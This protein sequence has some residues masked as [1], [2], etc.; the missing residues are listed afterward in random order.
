VTRLNSTSVTPVESVEDLW[1]VHLQPMGCDKCG[2]A[3]LAP[4]SFVGRPCPDCGRDRLIPQPALLRRE[5]PELAF[6][7]VKRRADLAHILR[8]FTRGVWIHTEDF[9]PDMLLQRAVPVYWPMWLVDSDIFGD[10]RAEMGYDYQV[11]SSQE[12]YQSGSW[13]TRPVVETRIRWEPRVGQITRRY[14]NIAAP[15]VSDHD[16]LIKLVGRYPLDKGIDYQPSMLNTDQG[17]VMMK[18]PDLPVESAWPLA[19][20]NLKKAAGFDCQ[21][22]AGAQHIR[23]FA[24]HAGYKS[25][26]WTQLLL[27]VYVTYYHD[28]EGNPKLV[29]VNGYSGSAGGLRLASQRKGWQWAGIMAAIAV[30]LFVLGMIFFGL[31]MVFPPSAVV[32]ILL[33]ILAFLGGAA[34]I[35]P[36]AWPWQWNRAQ[37]SQKVVRR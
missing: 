26:E 27:P 11:K 5:A 17:P 1:G 35:I 6:P 21:K 13:H 20:T 2:H 28:D 32:G 16:K 3:H 18:V 12:S 29:Y 31:A 14:N 4:A 9:T 34:A 37:Q 33:V 19:E 22:A 8:E 23:N 7:F 36:A 10:W 24:I 15:A 25:Q 30:A